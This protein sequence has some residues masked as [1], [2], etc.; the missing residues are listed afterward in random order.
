MRNSAFHR[1]AVPRAHKRLCRRC[2][3]QALFAAPANNLQTSKA[4]Q[5]PSG[6][7]A[8]AAQQVALTTIFSS[9]TMFA[10]IFIFK[11]MGVF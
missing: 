10:M 8:E 1:A 9:I 7:R 4:E 11:T 6:S 5:R 2:N 3:R